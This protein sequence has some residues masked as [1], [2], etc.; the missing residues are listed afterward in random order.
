MAF[1]KGEAKGAKGEL[2]DAAAAWRSRTEAMKDGRSGGSLLKSVLEDVS[3]DLKRWQVARSALEESGGSDGK[4]ALLGVLE[5]ERDKTSS[6]ANNIGLPPLLSQGSNGGLRRR[7]PPGAPPS[8]D[9]RSANA[10]ARSSATPLSPRRRAY[11][12]AHEERASESLS[13]VRPQD[14]TSSLPAEG[15]AHR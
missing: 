5:R 12:A 9:V 6:N 4:Y 2:G 3:V 15:P 1:R 7:V 13:S 14:P 11:M 8:I 10:A